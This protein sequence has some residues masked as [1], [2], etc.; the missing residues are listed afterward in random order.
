MNYQKKN[1]PNFHFVTANS[2]DDYKSGL[3]CC[4]NSFYQKKTKKIIDDWKYKWMN[5]PKLNYKN[6]L[7]VKHNKKI[8]GGIRTNDF[9]IR[10][11]KQSYK[12]S[13][14]CEIFVDPKYRNLGLSSSLVDFFINI[15]TKQKLDIAVLSARKKI[16]GFYQK[17]N[18]YG[19]GSYPQIEIKEINTEKK[20]ELNYTFKKVFSLKSKSLIKQLNG[21]YTSSYKNIFT[22]SS[23]D[24][25]RWEYYFKLI[26]KYGYEFILIYSR[27]KIVGYLIHKQNDIIEFAFDKNVKKK[28]LIINISKFFKKKQ[29]I[30]LISPKHE[31]FNQ[32]FGFDINIKLRSCVYGGQQLRILN[33]PQIIKKFTTREKNFLKDKTK[34]SMSIFLNKILKNKNETNLILGQLYNDKVNLE[35]AHKLKKLSFNFHRLL[36]GIHTPFLDREL[37][38]SLSFEPF[39]ISLVDEFF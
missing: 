20:I 29:I 1:N 28:L 18:F 15:K 4:L 30:F 5:Y 35:H 16:D 14:I 19:F 36:L 12:A 37:S 31:L 23:R 9:E 6:L 24:H 38:K 3:E 10:R 27:R 22:N 7:L 11:L 25:D 8:I 13:S 21:F 26:K 34:K 17:K 32:D 33:V 39:S 2:Y